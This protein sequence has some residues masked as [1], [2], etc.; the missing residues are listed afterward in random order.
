[1]LD[2]NS[3]WLIKNLTGIGA[4]VR[5]VQMIRDEYDEI[6]ATFR[7]AIARKPRLILTTGGLGPTDD[8][9]TARAISRTFGVPLE[10]NAVALEMLRERYAYLATIR[11]GYS[12]D[13]NDARR[14]MALMPALCEPLA[15]R[16]GAAP[17]LC[18]DVDT[19]TGQLVAS[20]SGDCT[21][22]CLP[23]VPK[24][25]KEIFQNSLQP[26]LA[27]TV[28]AGGYIERNIILDRGDESRI[29]AMLQACQ[30]R[31]PQVYI[32]SRGQLFADL[33]QRLTVVLS[34]GGPDLTS[35]R[36]LETACEQDVVFGLRELGYDIVRVQE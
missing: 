16:D 3:H 19:T 20:G 22:V 6:E 8:D 24:E 18:L 14:K 32:K 15:N 34:I 10:F 31:H 21:I 26:V 25:M 9:L 28:G 12:A 11:P 7:G 5:R 33:G 13:L 2:T 17:A 27:R 29:A 4:I 23:G 30:E 35:V 1:V 36:A